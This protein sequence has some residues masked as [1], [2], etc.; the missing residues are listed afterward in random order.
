MRCQLR[1]FSEAIEG[2]AL[3]TET[4][5]NNPRDFGIGKRL[6]NLPALRAVGCAANR[7]LLDVQ[8][9]SQD[10][11]IGE[12]ALEQVDRPVTVDGQRVAGLRF[13]DPRVQA[14]MSVLVLLFAMFVLAFFIPKRNFS[15][16]AATS[17]V[18]PLGNAQWAWP[19]T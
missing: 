19:P 14:L 11:A 7:R 4:T 12:A 2:R 16:K 3:R 8:R 10:C 5:I 13:A 15:T 1:S 9:V 17:A 18:W 6:T